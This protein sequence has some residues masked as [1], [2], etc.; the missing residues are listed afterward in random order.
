[1]KRP[2]NNIRPI[3]PVFNFNQGND[4]NIDSYSRRLERAGSNVI[5]K[6]FQEILDIYTID[7]ST[8]GQYEEKFF[9]GSI[10]ISKRGNIELAQLRLP[11]FIV[12]PDQK[13]LSGPEFDSRQK[14]LT[15]DKWKEMN[16][17][18]GNIVSDVTGAEYEFGV[19][20]EDSIQIRGQHGF[21]SGVRNSGITPH[22][23]FLRTADG[24]APINKDELVDVISEINTIWQE[25][26][27]NLN[28]VDRA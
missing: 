2:L 23:E 17:E 27:F 16:D 21:Q 20:Q 7:I 5:R 11:T 24:T 22:V 28:V 15:V 6:E 26:Y 4:F 18:L 14:S 25:K 12:Q 13:G 1:M 9:P 3:G 8:V 19:I 10:E